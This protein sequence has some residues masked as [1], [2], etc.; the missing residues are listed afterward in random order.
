MPTRVLIIQTAFIGDV[1]LVT[2]LVQAAKERLKADLVSVV[3]RPSTAELLYNNPCVDEIIPYDKKE[4]QKGLSGLIHRARMLD[5]FC[6]IPR[7]RSLKY[8]DSGYSCQV[9]HEIM[10]NNV[11]KSLFI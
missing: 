9:S 3:V 8:R 11:I 7:S 4:T 1:V 10:C 6:G 5:V 2:P